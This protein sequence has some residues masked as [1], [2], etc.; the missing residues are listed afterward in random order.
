MK[1]RLNGVRVE[2]S[3]PLVAALCI[4]LTVDTTFTAFCAVLNAVLHE[5]G[6]ILLL[7]Y[8]GCTVKSIKLSLFDINIKKS[9]SA[10]SLGQEVAVSLSGSIANIICFALFLFFY[11][12]FGVKLVLT[13]SLSALCLACFNLLPVESLDGGCALM[14]LM[15]KKLDH[16]T[17]SLILTIISC[18]VLLPMAVCGIVLLLKSK[19]NFTLLFTSCYLIGIILLRQKRDFK[20]YK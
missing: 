13:L 3:F 2:L 17:A 8:Y 16:K 19:Y 10:L 14:L 6:H 12:L 9:E 20:L 5:L 18:L 15:L 11:I 1:F 4:V 7:R